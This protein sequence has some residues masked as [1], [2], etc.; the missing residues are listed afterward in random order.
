MRAIIESIIN[1]GNYILSDIL[2]KINVC[3]VNGEITES[4]R[5]WLE[6]FAKEKANAQYEASEGIV[7]KL[8]ELDGRIH[9]LEV[10]VA[11]MGTEEPTE[12]SEPAEEQAP[13]FVVGK[14]YY[15]GDKVTFD[16]KQYECIAPDGQVCVWSPADYPAY[17][18]KV[19]EGG[20]EE[21]PTVEPTD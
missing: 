21:Q 6:N 1:Q 19:E 12:P 15:K 8:Q 14:W 16:G 10:K 18:Q 13:D 9:T 20:K 11:E 4:D 7:S 3:W 2:H 5:E 17:W